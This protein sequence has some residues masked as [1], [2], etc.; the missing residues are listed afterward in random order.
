MPA[1]PV[2]LPP[3]VLMASPACQEILLSCGSAPGQLPCI[4]D[5]LHAREVLQSCANPE[6]L[7][8]AA[9]VAL[10]AAG[11]QLQGAVRSHSCPAHHRRDPGGSAPHLSLCWHLLVPGARL[12]LR[13]PGGCAVIESQEPATIVPPCLAARFIPCIHHA[14]CLG[15]G[16]VVGEIFCF[17]VFVTQGATLKFYDS[18][19]DVL[20][21]SIPN[22]IPDHFKVRFQLAGSV[23]AM[24]CNATCCLHWQCCISVCLI[25][26]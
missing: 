17:F 2:Y 7:N 11:I 13:V 26:E 23:S 21:L 18:H 12:Q 9:A 3:L 15:A 16:A 14:G 4:T 10:Q 1:A 20:L 8:P 25:E 22:V 6:T 5:A 24:V 19:A